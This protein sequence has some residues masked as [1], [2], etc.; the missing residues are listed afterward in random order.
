MRHLVRGEDVASEQ[1]RLA[2]NQTGT[3]ARAVTLAPLKHPR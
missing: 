3:L 1:K 2:S